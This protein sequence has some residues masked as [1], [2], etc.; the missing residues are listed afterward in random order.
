MKANE[1]HN[2]ASYVNT[3]MDIRYSILHGWQSLPERLP[4]DL[5]IAIAP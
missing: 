5:D 1:N 3:S 2:L 4:S